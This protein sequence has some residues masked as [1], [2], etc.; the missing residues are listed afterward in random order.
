MREQG[1]DEREHGVNLIERCAAVSAL[2]GKIFFLPKNQVVEY[3][4]VL[5][6][7]LAFNPSHFFQ[8]GRF[9]QL[10]DRICK[11]GGDLLEFFRI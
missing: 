2:E 5:R 4:E 9:F 10:P 7:S 1:V 6:R 11:K 3:G 8:R